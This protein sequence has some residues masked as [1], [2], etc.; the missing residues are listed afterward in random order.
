MIEV[1]L[2]VM[3]DDFKEHPWFSK[4]WLAINNNP[5]VCT[6][7]PGI[8]LFSKFA[9]I[10]CN[11]SARGRTKTNPQVEGWVSNVGRGGNLLLRPLCS[12]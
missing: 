2:A 10:L 1:M 6:G 7:N 4:S 11:L 5:Q 8:P 12:E 9:P 3:K